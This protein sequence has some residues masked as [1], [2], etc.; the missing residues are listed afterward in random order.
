MLK[1]DE[2]VEAFLEHYASEDYDPAKAHEYYERTKELKGRDPANRVLDTSKVYSR[3][4]AGQKAKEAKGKKA[5]DPRIEALQRQQKAEVERFQENAKARREKLQENLKGLAKA[6]TDKVKADQV[7]AAANVEEVVKKVTADRDV[8]LKQIADMA[9][10]R[11][12]G[13]PSLPNGAGPQA[14]AARAKAVQRIQKGAGD[15]ANAVI[16][17][18]KTEFDKAQKIASALTTSSS[19]SAS[20][21]L[22]QLQDGVKKEV[23]K[24]NTELK[25]SV[26]S[27]RIKYENLKKS[28]L[29]QS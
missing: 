7:Q 28:L 27:A 24:V 26:E 16:G 8:K 9:Q 11:I 23:E 13:L 4:P 3:G 20:D 10:R 22:A 25:K 21:T 1:A 2:F 29:A 17:S 14:R 6:I 15:E 18:A 5:P 12:D 19:A